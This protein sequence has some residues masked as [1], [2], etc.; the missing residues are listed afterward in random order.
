[1]GGLGC[2]LSW[3]GDDCLVFEPVAI[4]GANESSGEWLGVE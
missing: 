1:M 4:L 3:G 2:F